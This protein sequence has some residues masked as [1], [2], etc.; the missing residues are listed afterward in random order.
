MLYVSIP[1]FKYVQIY[2]NNPITLCTFINNHWNM[3]SAWEWKPPCKLVQSTTL[4]KQFLPQLSYSLWKVYCCSSCCLK[5]SLFTFRTW[6][7]LSITSLVALNDKNIFS[8]DFWQM[9]CLDE[10]GQCSILHNCVVQVV[11]FISISHHRY[12]E[13]FYYTIIQLVPYLW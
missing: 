12:Y 10:T 9:H 7:E 3:E 13:L 5:N 2:P 1:T 11:S 8:F 6:Q 4:C